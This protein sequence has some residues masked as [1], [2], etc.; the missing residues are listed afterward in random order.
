M[1]K[2]HDLFFGVSHAIGYQLGEILYHAMVQG[3]FKKKEARGLFKDP[4]L[5]EGAPLFDL[6]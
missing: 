2:H 6:Q 5:E 3:K 4:F 1:L